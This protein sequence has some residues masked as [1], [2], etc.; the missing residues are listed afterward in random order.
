[1]DHNEFQLEEDLVE[2]FTAFIRK[3]SEGKAK[4][5]QPEK[6]EMSPLH[7]GDSKIDTPKSNGEKQIQL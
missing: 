1:M 3:L 2:P 7:L 4:D 6:K 5:T